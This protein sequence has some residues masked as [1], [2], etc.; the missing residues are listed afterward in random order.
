MSVYNELIKN[1]ERI[2]AYMRDFY[3][4]G[5]K[6]RGDY[7]QKSS[8]SYDDERRRMESWLGDHMSFV[9][10]PEGKNMFI[11]I[12]SRVI[13]HNPLY[14][15]WKTKSFTD[16]DI[17]LHFI[18][19]DILSTPDVTLSLSEIMAQVD[20]Y[21]AGF[22]SPLTFDE[23]TLRK[24]LKE[25]TAEGIIETIKQGRST[26]YRRVEDNFIVCDTDALHYFS[27]VSPCGVIGSYI[28]DKQPEHPDRMYFKHHYITSALDSDVLC[29][30][31]EAI[32][33]KSYVTLSSFTRHSK[34]ST[35]L[36][37][38]PLKVFISVQSG[39]HHLMAY[40]TSYQGIKSFRID[41]LSDAKIGKPCEDYDEHREKLNSAM[42]HMWGVNYNKTEKLK[43]IE[44]TIRAEKDEDYIVRRLY[45]EKRIGTVDRVDDTNYRFY[46][47]VYDTS[48]LVPWIRTFICRITDIRFSDRAAENLFKKDIEDMYNLYLSGG[49]PQ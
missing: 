32:H 30:L 34:E 13:S 35:E 42:K 49:E 10:S 29:T 20:T 40:D 45:R 47:Q 15:A 37:L 43:E 17:T 46:A 36:T 2:R 39:R 16:R 31:F 22:E 26:A 27:E 48:E 33:R 11:S 38:V 19:F 23:S 25:Y 6:S 1:F 8:R 9:R 41:Y 3:V 5:F 44:F 18:L 21:L 14:K 28:L 7:S 24:K 4:Y 12:D